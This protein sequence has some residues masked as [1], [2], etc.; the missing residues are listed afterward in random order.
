MLEVCCGSY[1]DAL[2]ASQAG[3]K[4][5]EL[6]SA[7]PLGGLTPTTATLDMIKRNTAMEVIC[8]VRCRE[9]GFFYSENEYMQMIEEATELL[10]HGADGIAFGFLDEQKNLS[11][12]RI[13][14]MVTLIHSYN[15]IAVFHRAFDVM[16]NTDSIHMLYELGIDRVL[17]SGQKPTAFAG[18]E[19][20]K[21]LQENYGDKIEIVAGCG[22]TYENVLHIMKETGIINI[23]SSCKEYSLD[24]TTSGSSVSFSVHKN[25]YQHVSFSKVKAM[26]NYLP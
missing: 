7:L 15:K 21:N 12:T 22:I 16:E 5:I 10:E 4:R 19:T 9:G 25:E 23:H 8:M 13:R 18:I 24:P 20:L 2:T 26:M 6:N 11:V 3:A 14:N 1:E 17:T